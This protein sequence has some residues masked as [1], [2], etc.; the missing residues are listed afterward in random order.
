MQAL[1]PT[2]FVTEAVQVEFRTVSNHSPARHM[3]AH[4]KAYGNAGAVRRVVGILRDVTQRHKDDEQLRQSSVVFHAT[5][6]AIVIT[7]AS[8]DGCGQHRIFT[9]YRLQR[10]RNYRLDPDL[11][12]RVSP[13]PER[14]AAS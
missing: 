7:D 3:E 1:N 11:L 14:Y 13:G 8:G 2:C 6:E 4:A 12:L 5:A 9:N 10:R